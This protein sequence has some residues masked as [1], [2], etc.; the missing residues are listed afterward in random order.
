MAKFS[1][2][3]K[4]E[5]KQR[6]AG[7]CE[8]C[9]TPANYS[10]SPFPSE[11]IQPSSKGG[12][13]DL[14]NVAFACNG[15]NWYK[16]NKTG[17]TIQKTATFALLFNPRQQIWSNHFKWSDDLLK[18]VGLTPTGTITI[19]ILKLNTEGLVNLRFALLAIGI[20]PPNTK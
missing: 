20:H 11:H 19:E 14:T 18:I 6:A 15:C 2:K 12:I 7:R 1:K 3:Q 10:P 17:A 16:G 13:D 8:Y 5:I 9:Q 4:S